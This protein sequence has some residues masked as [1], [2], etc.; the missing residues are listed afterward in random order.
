MTGMTFFIHAQIVSSALIKL[1]SV[2]IGDTV[3]VDIKVTIPAGVTIQSLDFSDFRNIEN[4]V[5]FNDTVFFDK[6]ADIEILNFGNWKHADPGTPV[7]I[8]AIQINNSGG[9]QTITNKITIAIYNPGVFSIPGPKVV[10]Q[11]DFETLPSESDILLVSL[12]EKLM[13]QDTVTF[14]PIKDIM[15]EEA[16]ITDYLIYVYIFLALLVMVAIGYYFFRLKKKK[17]AETI[18]VFELPVLPAHEKALL[19]LKSLSEQ[20]LW[21]KGLIKEYQSGLTEIMRTY[22]EERYEIKALEMTTDEISM[23]LSKAGFN[24]KYIID[25]KEILQIADLVKFA[26]ATPQ[27]NIHSIFMD[28]A[29]EFVENTKEAEIIS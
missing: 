10:G 14:N 11:E 22:L 16:D 12:P 4:Q 26:K 18:P 17:E 3:S 5:Y 13:N 2:L 21:Q 6:Y 7:P 9:K 19:A 20:Q 23:A 1:D 25:L 27:E 15:H 28:R 8:D 24:T 29:V